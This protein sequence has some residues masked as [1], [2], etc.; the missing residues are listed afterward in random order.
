MKGASKGKV[1]ATTQEQVSQGLY[2]SFAYR[3]QVQEPKKTPIWWE[4]GRVRVIALVRT[5]SPI[6]KASLQL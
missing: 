6:P 1:K 5:D 4:R 3:K 2:C